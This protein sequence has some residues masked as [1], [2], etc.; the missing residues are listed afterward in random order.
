MVI[1]KQV[2][3]KVKDMSNYAKFTKWL[4]TSLGRVSLSEEEA[5]LEKFWPDIL[6]DYL[7]LV[8]GVEQITLA[9][10]SRVQQIIV[11]SENDNLKKQD[12]VIQAK[13][14]ALP[15]L[16][17]N[18]D[19]VL[20]PHVLEFANNPYQVLREAEI[21]VQ[22][23][24]YIIV[25]GFNPFSLWGLRRLFTLR[26][27][28]P[29]LGHFRSAIRTREWL[30]VLNFEIIKQQYACYRPPI[31]SRGIFK[32]LGWLEKFYRVCLPFFGGVYV[33]LAKKKVYGM[34][35]RKKGWRKLPH[36]VRN[37]FMK[38]ATGE[39]RHEKNN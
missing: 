27:K 31:A 35:V 19:V 18:M 7:L 33:I 22:P 1:E 13:Y 39:M 38:P 12:H 20:L 36:L 17:N 21:S 32:R 37:G 26:K 24:G 3:V 5:C 25:I 16:P 9:R 2:M 28:A 15:I 10:E 6:G 4:Q 11:L 30:K 23:E 8:G 34:T 14:D 29:W